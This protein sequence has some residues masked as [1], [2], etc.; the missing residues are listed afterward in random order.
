MIT[1]TYVIQFRAYPGN[2]FIL[3]PKQKSRDTSMDEHTRINSILQI[4]FD[5]LK[6]L[7]YHDTNIFDD[8]YYNRSDEVDIYCDAMS[9]LHTQPK[10]FIIKGE[11]GI[12]KTTFIH[13]LNSRTDI[14]DKYKVYPLVVDYRDAIPNTTDGCIFIFI[15]K[16]KEY[17]HSIK[18]PLTSLKDNK[19]ENNLFNIN[20]IKLHIENL[21]YHEL[22]K[23]LILFLD[24]FDYA[25]DNWFQLL[26]Y[27][28]PLASSEK[29]SLVL[30]VRPQLL[31]EID[32]Y[33]DRFRYYY[34]RSAMTFD[35]LPL[36]IEYIISSRIAPILTEDENKPI[37]AYFKKLF[38][39]ESRLCKIMNKLGVENIKDLNRI[40]YP[41]SKKHNIFMKRITNGNIRE[42]FDIA[43]TSLVYIYENF[44]RLPSKIEED[45]SEKKVIG[46]DG[47]MSL[48]YDNKN[49][50]YKIQNIHEIRS[51]KDCSL[52]YNV[53]EGV[54]LFRKLDND[55]YSLLKKLGH[56]KTDVDFAIKNLSCKTGRFINPIVILPEERRQ[57]RFQF[58]EYA[59]TSKGEFY[60]EMAS[61][62]SEY[63][64][65]CGAIGKSLKE[66][67]K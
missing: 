45:G 33:D 29:L 41:M 59:L 46:R 4:A 54:K 21:N 49:S 58:P 9:K 5:D 60:L 10:N 35:L 61:D 30:S 11:A 64:S 51:K 8:L 17:F 25:E 43:L 57:N 27:F 56:E 6:R 28:L 62:W 47:V 22:S 55:F 13:R 67:Y 50:T 63:I 40:K 3:T 32:S 23:R 37:H 34:V 65:R 15:E 39:R 48:F 12:G 7:S 31:A 16:I 66:I 24:D 44:D 53:L 18:R 19:S 42:V 2:S 20:M 14:L 38:G 52:L 36:S 26:G 1:S